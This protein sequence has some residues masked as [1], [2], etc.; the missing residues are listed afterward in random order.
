MR[1]AGSAMNYYR[2]VDSITARI[3]PKS[4]LSRRQ[5]R[6]INEGVG[7]EQWCNSRISPV[8]GAGKRAGRKKEKKESSR[9]RGSLPHCVF[10]SPER[11]RNGPI[12]HEEV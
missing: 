8:S 7:A 1:T 10:V 6:A 12:A 2:R 3:A 4:P 9:E 5:L 11:D